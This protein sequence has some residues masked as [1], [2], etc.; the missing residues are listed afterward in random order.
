MRIADLAGLFPDLEIEVDPEEMVLDV[1]I[2]LRAQRI[3]LSATET[4]LI[5]AAS[6]MDL[7]TQLGMFEAAKIYLSG[8]M[9]E[10]D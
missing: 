7:I 5:S 4:A 9:T 1:V 10:D 2:L 3:D 6:D 8:R